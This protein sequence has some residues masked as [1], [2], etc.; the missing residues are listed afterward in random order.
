MSKIG[1]K[2][3]PLPAG[4]Q[5]SITGNTVVVKGSKGT[6]QVIVPMELVI[7]KKDNVL[8][9]R[10]QDERKSTKAMHGLFRSLIAN[11]VAGVETPWT[12]RL[13]IVGTGFTAKLQGADLALKIGFSHTV[14]YKKVENIVFQVEGNNKIVISGVDKQLVGQVAYQIKILKKPDPYKGKGIRY[15][16]EVIKLKPGKKAKTAAA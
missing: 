8:N 5:L 15:D 12:K 2:P 10:R 6:M 1:E 11:A 3:V 16:G 13:E 7:E 4:V 9:L 14:I